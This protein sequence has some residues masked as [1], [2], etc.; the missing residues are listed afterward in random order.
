MPHKESLLYA[1]S[2]AGSVYILTVTHSTAQKRKDKTEILCS[3]PGVCFPH[4][5]ME[6]QDVN[7]IVPDKI[8]VLLVT[9]C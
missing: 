4:I 7:M 9:L 6:K 1:V 5:H 8:P 2:P 3:F